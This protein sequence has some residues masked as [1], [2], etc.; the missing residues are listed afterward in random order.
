MLK[1]GIKKIEGL[2]RLLLES[3][4]FLEWTISVFFYG[5]IQ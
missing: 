4:V 1:A 3:D 5:H 2:F